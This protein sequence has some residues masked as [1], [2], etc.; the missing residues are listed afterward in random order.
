MGPI[1]SSERNTG[2][3]VIEGLNILLGLME[4][5]HA[6]EIHAISY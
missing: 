6:N 3:G 1:I 4:N 5:K 2:K